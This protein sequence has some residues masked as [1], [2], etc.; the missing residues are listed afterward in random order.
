VIAVCG[1]TSRPAGGGDPGLH[2]I[3]ALHAVRYRLFPSLGS[4]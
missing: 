2:L 1:A 3:A 4:L